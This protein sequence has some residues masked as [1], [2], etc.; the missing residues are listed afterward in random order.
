MFKIRGQDKYGI[1]DGERRYRCC[2]ELFEEKGADTKLPA[3]I[4]APPTKVAGLIYM[5]SIHN[6]R[7]QWELMPTALGLK[8]VM[9]ELNETDSEVLST[10]TG[11]SEPQIE[12]CKKLLEFPKKYTD[13]SMDSDPDTRIPSNFW[14]EALPVINLVE[15]ELPDLK[16]SLG[17]NGVIEKLVNKYRAN[18]IKSVIHFR[19][20]MESYEVIAD[21]RN[22]ILDT[23]RRYI[24]DP[25]LETREAFD[26]FIV[27]NMRI[28]GAIEAANDFVKRLE[29]AKLEFVADR[30]KLV[31]AL[32]R[33]VKFVDKLLIKLQGSDPPGGKGGE[34]R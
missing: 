25:A 26:R 17:R 24:L 10:I 23:L 7:E 27:D 9:E 31:P 8:T 19:R 21:R 18:S 14:I 30:E 22:E 15:K 2:V 6:F 13:L 12:R 34:I 29:R 4:V 16:K 32:K 3:N 28:E 20:I 1:L 5:F 11:L 33:V